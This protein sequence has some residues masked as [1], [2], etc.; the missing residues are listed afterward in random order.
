M[1]KQTIR[2]LTLANT[3]KNCVVIICFTLLAVYFNKWWISIFGIL[4]LSN[5]KY[6]RK[7]DND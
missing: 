1:D 5:L 2:N 7:S 6:I 4:G 3:I